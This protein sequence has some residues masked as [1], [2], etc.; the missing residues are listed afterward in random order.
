MTTATFEDFGIS[1]IGTTQ[2]PK[3][4]TL[5][6]QLYDEA[7][8]KLLESQQY[9]A[10]L[11]AIWANGPDTDEVARQIA[12]IGLSANESMELRLQRNRLRRALR[13]LADDGGGTRQRLG[14]AEARLAKA[15]QRLATPGLSGDEID[16][17][18]HEAGR[19]RYQK[20]QIETQELSSIRVAENCVKAL[21]DLGWPVDGPQ[22]QATAKGKKQ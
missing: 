9:R 2:P 17:F 3:G 16:K 6:Q 11:S 13:I 5:R 14:E 21:C 12:D 7:N 18:Q 20:Q 4:Q 19:L 10:L 1:P 22:E 8:R 15:E